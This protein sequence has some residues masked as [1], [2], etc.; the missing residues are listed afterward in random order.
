MP[1]TRVPTG[2]PKTQ[3]EA[4]RSRTHVRRDVFLRVRGYKMA[5]MQGYLY[6]MKTQQQAENVSDLLVLYIGKTILSGS[7]S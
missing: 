4:P 6:R 5:R 2:V 3:N 7:Y 1:T